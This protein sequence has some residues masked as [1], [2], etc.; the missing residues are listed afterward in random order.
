M[1]KRT[2]VSDRPRFLIHW[3]TFGP[4]DALGG[5]EILPNVDESVLIVRGVGLVGERV[6]CQWFLTKIIYKF[7]TASDQIQ[8]E[9]HESASY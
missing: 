9:D 2:R 3:A 1:P 6:G 5:G 7:S 8:Y 4:H